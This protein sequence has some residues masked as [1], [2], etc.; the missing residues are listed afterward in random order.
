[1]ILAL[2]ARIITLTVTIVSLIDQS[3][4][5]YCIEK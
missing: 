4:L 2:L 5:W 3:D 1:V